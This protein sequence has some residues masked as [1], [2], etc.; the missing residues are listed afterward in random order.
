MAKNHSSHASEE[1]WELYDALPVEVQE[2]ADKQ[3][4]LF[5]ENLF[6]PSLRLKQIGDLWIA[7]VS[8]SYRALAWR[9]GNVFY[10]FWIGNHE[11]YEEALKR[12]M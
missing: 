10:W 1:F 8:R 6:H 7:R 12:L 4:T 2:Q 5:R 9:Q 11:D 3:F